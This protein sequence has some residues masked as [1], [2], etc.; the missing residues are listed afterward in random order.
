[1]HMLE[2]HLMMAEGAAGVGAGCHEMG[3]FPL[4]WPMKR[5]ATMSGE[6]EI[7]EVG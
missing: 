4:T 7:E 6:A 5:P 3:L 1:M 2:T